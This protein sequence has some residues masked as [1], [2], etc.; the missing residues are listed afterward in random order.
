[1][2]SGHKVL[3]LTITLVVNENPTWTFESP[4]VEKRFEVH[5]PVDLFSGRATGEKIAEYAEKMVGEF[6]AAVAEY[7]AEVARE[8]AEEEARKELEKAQAN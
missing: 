7:E 5:L 8:K 4:K 1:M 2:K 6:P 3:H